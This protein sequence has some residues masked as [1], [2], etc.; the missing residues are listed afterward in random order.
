[1][2]VKGSSCSSGSINTAARTN[3][4]LEQKAALHSPATAAAAA[5]ACVRGVRETCNVAAGDTQAKRPRWCRCSSS[6]SEQQRQLPTGG[7]KLLGFGYNFM[8]RLSDKK[9]RGGGGL[10]HQA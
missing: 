4:G 6:H 10:S 1:M 7:E 5:T 3:C 2:R 8:M 9:E